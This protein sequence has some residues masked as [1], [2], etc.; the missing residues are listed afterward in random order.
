[1]KILHKITVSLLMMALPYVANAQ[2]SLSAS[3]FDIAAGGEATFAVSMENEGQQICAAQFDMALPDGLT[4]Q[5]AQLADAR[6]V[7]HGIDSNTVNGKIRVSVMDPEN[8]FK[9]NQGPIAYV[10]VKASSS[11][12]TGKIGFD[13]ISFSSLTG[14]AFWGANFDIIVNPDIIETTEG[15]KF[16][17]SPESLTLEANSEGVKQGELS[18]MLDSPKYSVTACQFDLTLPDGVKVASAKGTDRSANLKTTAKELDNGCVR[19][20]MADIKMPLLETITGTEGAICIITFEATDNNFK[21]GE[22]KIDNIELAN[23]DNLKCNPDDITVSISATA[24]IENVTASQLNQGAIYNLQ[25]VKVAA[26]SLN[27][28]VYIQ[29]G[30]KFVV[31]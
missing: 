2:V 15:V 27:K 21:S 9:D 19:I 26:E 6:S 14:Q 5:S 13:F 12:K 28:G 3:D 29:N 16:Y 8:N 24:G 4:F 23:P 20:K 30:K 25:G 11:F 22:V 31:K 18:I 7:D 1:M 10:T 17:V